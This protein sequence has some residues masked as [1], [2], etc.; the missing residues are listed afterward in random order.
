M[1][2][3]LSKGLGAPVGSL[4]IVV[5]R[6]DRAGPGDPQADGRR[7]ASGRHPRRGRAGT[8][9]PTTSSGW[10]RITTGPGR[11]AE[12]LAPFG[13]V[14][15]ARVRTNIVL[16]DLTKSA[17]DAPALG[18]AARERGVL[19]S[20][21]GPRVARLVTHLDVDDAGV[22]R[23]I[24]VLTARSAAAR[25][26]LRVLGDVLQVERLAELSR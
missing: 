20:V 9:W 18:A 19:V 1:S 3:C 4:V 26:L 23:A 12:A 13:V 21:I 5:G 2:V 16:L 25:L 10:P 14:D 17:L 6:A 24:E 11:L 22:D 8:R 15:A 7:H